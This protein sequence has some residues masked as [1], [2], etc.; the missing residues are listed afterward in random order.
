MPLSTS[1]ALWVRFATSREPRYNSVVSRKQDLNPFYSLVV[2]VGIAFVVTAL[3]YVVSLV[4]LQP[5][6]GTIAS[7]GP[8]PSSPVMRFIERR[9]ESLMLWEAAALTTAALLAMGLDRWRSWQARR[10]KSLVP[11]API[12]DS[13]N[14]ES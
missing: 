5:P 14:S 8:L 1:L 3:A 7:A 12:Q 11:S 9:G 2:L 10:A 4:R 6:A 13:R